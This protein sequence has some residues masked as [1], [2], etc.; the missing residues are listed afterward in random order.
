MLC[1]KERKVIISMGEKLSIMIQK[2][3]TCKTLSEDSP[4]IS[5]VKQTLPMNENVMF[6]AA[7]LPQHLLVEQKLNI[8]AL[9]QKSPVST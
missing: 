2:N 4:V 5:S 1:E 8:Q 3:I 7:Y 6:P 9:R